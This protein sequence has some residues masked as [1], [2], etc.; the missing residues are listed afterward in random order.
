MNSKLRINECWLDD[1][2]DVGHLT[3]LVGEEATLEILHNSR[4]GK[5][6]PD[7]FVWTPS[8]DGSF[9]TSSAWEVVRKKGEQ[10]Q[11]KEWIWHRLLPKRVSLCVWK[12]YYRC[13]AVDE[14]VEARGVALT[15]ACDCCVWKSG[16][17]LDH[18]L[19]SG[20]VATKVWE[21]ASTLL[22]IPCMRQMHWKARLLVWFRS[23][24]KA[25][26]KGILTGLLPCL[27][28]WQL[29]MRRCKARMEGMQDSATR[30]WWSVKYW[31]RS[32]SG[33]LKASNS[34]SVQDM[35]FLQDLQIHLPVQRFCQH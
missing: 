33:D 24:K 22:G 27:I 11:W 34:L 1:S 17:S 16:E 15:S 26:V 8:N 4:A 13:L 21:F 32:L 12:A 25:S 29:W 5:S 9:S 6:G 2:W 10:L 7:I 23:S 31:L 19:C 18:I 35:K 30:V 28:S 20:E 14:R 3:D